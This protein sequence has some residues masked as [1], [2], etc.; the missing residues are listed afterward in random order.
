MKLVWLFLILITLSCASN[1]DRIVIPKIDENFYNQ[2]LTSI[3]DDL[4]SDKNN[5]Q[6]V[7][8]KLYYC[9]Q[10]DWPTNC[11]T[12][13]DEYKRQKG[14][15]PQL[16]DQYIY[17]YTKHDRYQ[18]LL[19]VIDRWASDFE[20]DDSYTKDR[21]EAL[22]AVSRKSQAQELL[23]N[24]MANRKSPES[25]EFAAGQ[26]L[27]LRDTVMATYYLGKLEKLSEDHPLIYRNYPYML[28][29]LGL[30]D[31]AYIILERYGNTQPNDYDFH[32]RLS[33]IYEADQQLAE[34]RNAIKGFIDR[35]TVV[36]RIADL[37]RREEQWDSAHHFIDLIIDRDS[38]NRRAWW[39]KAVMYEDRGWLT[40]SLNYFDH[41]IYLNENDTIARQRADLVRR[42]IAYLQ[43]QKI[44]AMPLPVL[45]SKKISDNE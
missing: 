16:L 17:Y 34:A 37:F 20:V 40:Y 14:M 25:I 44:E 11:L 32:M 22:A 45:E 28:V 35:D 42:K 3:D 5:L 7:E 8:Q 36:Y 1:R 27:T 43:R 6:L 12:A 24:Y 41:L 39:T 10:L 18:L 29:D 19:D 38:V 30:Q 26:Y 33:A 15:T 2:A 21:I 31:Q 9:D 13:L 23:R 4:G